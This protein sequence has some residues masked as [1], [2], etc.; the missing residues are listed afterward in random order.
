MQPQEVG[1]VWENVRLLAEWSPLISILRSIV[2]EKDVG[3]QSLLVMDALEWLAAKSKNK[4]DDELARLV[5]AIVRTPEGI[6]MI[7]F[8]IGYI[9]EGVK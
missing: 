8:V 2:A 4:L 3:R 5:A 6:A 7:K 9:E 1:G